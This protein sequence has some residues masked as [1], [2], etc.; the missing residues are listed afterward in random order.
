MRK[1]LVQNSETKYW[2]TS[3]FTSPTTKPLS[4]AILMMESTLLIWW[5]LYSFSNLSVTSPTPQLILKPFRRFTY[6]AAHSL[7]LPLLHLRHSSFSNPS[8][9]SPTSQALHLIHLA[10]RP[11]NVFIWTRFF[12][13]KRQIKETET[14]HHMICSCEAL[15]HRRHSILG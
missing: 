14:A 11:C 2:T 10:S 9:A 6:V 5:S 3:F 8:F 12:F 7:T 4:S 13:S 15:A 1:H